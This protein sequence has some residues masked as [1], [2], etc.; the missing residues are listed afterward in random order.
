MTGP[1]K[2]PQQAQPGGPTPTDRTYVY[3]SFGQAEA[4]DT[5][6]AD[7][8]YP[9]ESPDSPVPY[10]LTAKAETLLGEPGFP[11]TPLRNAHSRD[12]STQPL[13]ARSGLSGQPSAY[14][15]EI[16]V[17]PSDSRILRLLARMKEPEPEAGL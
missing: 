5:W 7:V 10:T 17:P 15:T 6:T 13:H 16:S 3:Q 14:V 2:G 4:P 12:V 8:A 1:A 9:A 11:A